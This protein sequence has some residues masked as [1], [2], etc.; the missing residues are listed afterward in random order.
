[1]H[2]VIDAVRNMFLILPLF[3]VGKVTFTKQEV[4]VEEDV[5]L[6]CQAKHRTNPLHLRRVMWH[7]KDASSWSLVLT[8]DKKNVSHDGTKLHSNGSLL[9]PS[10]RPT[11]DVKYKCDVIKNITS[12]RERHIILVK[13]VKCHR[14]KRSAAGTY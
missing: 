12:R 3:I 5:L 11:S 2:S 8:S 10:G 9:L 14:E 1:M 7:K 4:C 13:N 6:D